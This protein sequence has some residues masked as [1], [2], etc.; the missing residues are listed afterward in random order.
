MSPSCLVFFRWQKASWV[1]GARS[2]LLFRYNPENFGVSY[3]NI[4]QTQVYLPYLLDHFRLLDLIS[5]Y[6]PPKGRLGFMS[7][8]GHDQ[9]CWCT[10]VTGKGGQITIG[11]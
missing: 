6:L 2:I 5:L 7:A 8:G 3:I 1:K 11:H 10:I 9:G 4:F